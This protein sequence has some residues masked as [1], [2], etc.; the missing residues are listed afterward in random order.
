MI[1]KVFLKFITNLSIFYYNINVQSVTSL[2]TSLS[3]VTKGQKKN[4]FKCLDYY[5]KL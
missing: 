4:I 3:L 2:R 1:Y 5:Q